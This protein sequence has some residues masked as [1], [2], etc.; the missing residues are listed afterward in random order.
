MRLNGCEAFIIELI[1]VEPGADRPVGM[2]EGRSTCADHLEFA[3][4][5]R[6]LTT[7]PHMKVTEEDEPPRDSCQRTA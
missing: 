3:R 4:R 2:I 6:E 1:Q 7:Y 5:R